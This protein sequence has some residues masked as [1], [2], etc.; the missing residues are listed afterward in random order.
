MID[1]VYSNV[2][3]GTGTRYSIFASIQH[4]KDNKR[5]GVAKLGERERCAFFWPAIHVLLLVEDFRSLEKVRGQLNRP[6][7]LIN[8]GK[9]R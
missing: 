1:H 2:P 5:G 6:L 4:N 3:G 7:H 9:P 8:F